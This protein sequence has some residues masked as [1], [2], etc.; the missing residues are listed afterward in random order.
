M[1]HN[2]LKSAFLSIFMIFGFSA[3]GKVA[4][5]PGAAEIAP[6]G[7]GGETHRQNSWPVLFVEIQGEYCIAPV[8]KGDD[9]NNL[10]D[11]IRVLEGGAFL[12]SFKHQR[13]LKFCQPEVTRMA[14]DSLE[15]REL[16]AVFTVPIAAAGAVYIGFCAAADY[17]TTKRNKQVKMWT[18]QDS[19]YEEA[20]FG[21]NLTR[22]LLSISCAPLYV[23][24]AIIRW[25]QE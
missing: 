12:E 9:L 23:T 14:Y 10:I 16:A 6:Y 15:S 13:G 22:G 19:Q 2:Q 4:P 21:E 17:A 5:D 1:K 25:I 11:K 20:G 8:K 24:G 7:R 3:T 18:P